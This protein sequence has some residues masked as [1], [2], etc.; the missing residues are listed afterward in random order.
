MGNY[1]GGFGG[2]NMQQL[3]KQAQKMQEEL[4]KQQEEIQNS[5]VTSR[6]GGGAVEVVMSGKFKVESITIKPEVVD[7]ADIETLEDLIKA[8]IND[9]VGQI[10]RLKEEKMPQV[11]GGLF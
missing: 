3:M 5:T 10:E 1:M 7:P 9:A 8:G 6:V 4:L 11:P 2:G